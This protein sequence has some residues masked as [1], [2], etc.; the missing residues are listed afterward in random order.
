MIQCMGVNSFDF[1]KP[2]DSFQNGILYMQREAMDSGNAHLIHKIIRKRFIQSSISILQPILL[3]ILRISVSS[4]KNSSAFASPI[5][6]LN[7]AAH[8][9]S[10]W[11]SVYLKK[12]IIKQER[13][14]GDMSASK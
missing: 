10:C 12:T 13:S 8:E 14:S 9:R 4:N 6:L 1:G 3:Y 7:D 11:V 5:L 2:R